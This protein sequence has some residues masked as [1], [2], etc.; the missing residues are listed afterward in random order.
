MNGKEDEADDV[1]KGRSR[2]WTVTA[3]AFI[4]K[5]KKPSAETDESSE[6]GIAMRRATVSNAGAAGTVERGV[7]PHPE[8]HEDALQT[9]VAQLRLGS[10]FRDPED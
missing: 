3:N 8:T 5:P 4:G 10:G 1:K 6:E 9:L 7:A 2:T